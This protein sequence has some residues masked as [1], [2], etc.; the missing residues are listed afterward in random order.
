MMGQFRVLAFA[1]SA[2]LVSGT[3]T[4]AQMSTQG[5]TRCA[6]CSG[7]IC[8]LEAS[9][10]YADCRQIIID[11]KGYC[12]VVYP[13]CGGYGGLAPDGLMMDG[14]VRIKDIKTLLSS[15]R[16]SDFTTAW[17]TSG[18]NDEITIT[19]S[20]CG[21]IVDRSYSAAGI[22]RVRKETQVLTI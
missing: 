21:A 4:Y 18:V 11:D 20:K 13:W 10:G 12:E 6:Y 7:N 16:P 1:V 3:N 22:E 19:R 9:H 14:S 15:G 2:L 5:P 8:V 17:K